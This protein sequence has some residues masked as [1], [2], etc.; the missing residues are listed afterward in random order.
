MD[1]HFCAPDISLASYGHVPTPMCMYVCGGV[2]VGSLDLL[3][4]LAVEKKI[5]ICMWHSGYLPL[6]FAM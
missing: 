6:Q 4:R 5:I 2:S 1:L 3:H